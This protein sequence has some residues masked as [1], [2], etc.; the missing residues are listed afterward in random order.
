MIATRPF[1]QIHQNKSHVM[2]KDARANER[3]KV[4][5][6]SKCAHRALHRAAARVTLYAPVALICCIVALFAT[7]TLH[8]MHIT[9]HR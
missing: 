4:V 9:N 6:R 1:S 5:G 2:L 8:L 3:A 7:E